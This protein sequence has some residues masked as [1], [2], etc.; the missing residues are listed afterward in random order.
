[1]FMPN[2]KILRK[3]FEMRRPPA[4]SGVTYQSYHNG[5]AEWLQQNN[6]TTQRNWRSICPERLFWY[7][8]HTAS[9]IVN[10]HLVRSPDRQSL[11]LF[12]RTRRT[13]FQLSEIH[14]TR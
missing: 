4:P 10:T 5:V 13:V 14:L 7:L 12:K 6:Q 9:N 8:P 3:K 1:M 11:L 2:W